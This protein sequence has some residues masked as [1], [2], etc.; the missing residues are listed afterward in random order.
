M[1]NF[2]GISQVHIPDMWKIHVPPNIHIFL[3]LLA[4][5]K[6]LVR[7]NLIKRQHLNDLSCL[8]CSECENINHL[9]FECAVAMEI[10][11]T[12]HS[13]TDCFPL[14][15]F[16]RV[17]EMWGKDKNL[18]AENLIIS[19]TLWAIWRCRNDLCFN[20]TNWMGV[21]VVL[22]KSAGY[23]NS[24]KTHCKGKA[25]ERVEMIIVAIWKAARKPLLLLWPEPG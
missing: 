7:E 11:R 23:C 2:R 15:A 14:P 19:A 20:N 10:W 9:F 24:W 12:I 16:G 17:A 18:Q 21:Q 13:I 6:L 8:F 1:I 22:R 3:W 25:R 4:H 5:N